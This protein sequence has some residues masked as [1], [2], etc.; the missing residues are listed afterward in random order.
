MFGGGGVNANCSDPERSGQVSASVIGELKKVTGFVTIARANNFITQPAVGD[1]VYQGDL[2]ETG[3]DGLVG[4]AFIDG[5]T[6][7]LHASASMALDE[8]TCGANKSFNSALFRIVKGVFGFISGKLATTGRLV[9]DTPV[10]QIQSVRPAAS[11]GSLAFGIFTFGLI[12]ELK[13]ASAD[14]ALLDDG[15][16]DPNELKHG[17]FVIHTKGDNPRDIVVDDVTATTVIQRSG[18]GVRVELVTKSPTEMAQL[19][20]A[21]QTAYAT[22]AQGLQDP[23]IQQLQH[24][25]NDHANAQPQSTQGATGSAK[26]LHH[27]IPRKRRF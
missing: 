8:F 17:V 24:S 22:Y 4:I 18:T 9:I 3:I 10:A 2:I 23:F 14:P 27:L 11:V 12:Q 5:T 15:A 16:I 1:P 6:F 25:A 21:Y 19:Q 26:I 7:Q 20:G 13:A